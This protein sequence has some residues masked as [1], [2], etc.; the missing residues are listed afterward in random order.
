[1][2]ANN[3]KTKVTYT[4]LHTLDNITK[5][6]FIYTPYKENIDQYGKKNYMRKNI[7]HMY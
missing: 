5:C 4:Y 6:L 3:D 7:F 1:M 2:N